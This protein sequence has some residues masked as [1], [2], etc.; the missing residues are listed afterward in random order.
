[1]ACLGIWNILGFP[2]LTVP[3]GLNSQGMPLGVTVVAGK[4]KDNVC[5]QVAIELEKEFKGWRPPCEV[6]ID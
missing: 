1:M 5:C 3:L 6:N 2:A 4:M